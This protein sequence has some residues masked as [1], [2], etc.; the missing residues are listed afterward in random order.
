[1]RFYALSWGYSLF[2]EQF[3]KRSKK[4]KNAKGLQR[5]FFKPTLHHD[6]ISLTTALT[7]LVYK[8]S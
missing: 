5:H 3:W 7:A 6:P 8:D 4:A 1:M 2:Q